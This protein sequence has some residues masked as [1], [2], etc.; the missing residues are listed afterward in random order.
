[1]SSLSASCPL[2]PLQAHVIAVITYS[3]SYGVKPEEKRGRLNEMIEE[4][5]KMVSA[6][7]NEFNSSPEARGERRGIV[8]L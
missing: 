4:G 2:P 5:L 3:R 1:M 6:V 8:V 7:C